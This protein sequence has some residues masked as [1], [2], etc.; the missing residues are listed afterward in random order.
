[1]GSV[2]SCV[3]GRRVPPD[4]TRDTTGHHAPTAATR[5]HV[6]WQQRLSQVSTIFPRVACT[7]Q[8]DT[9]DCSCPALAMR[10]P[11]DCRA[12][13]RQS[14]LTTAWHGARAPDA[15]DVLGVWQCRL[16]LEGPPDSSSASLIHS[17]LP[18]SCCSQVPLECA[19][20]AQGPH[21]GV[22]SNTD[23]ACSALH[24]LHGA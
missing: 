12:S 9:L 17:R 22:G 20:H 2:G 13:R 15:N 24:P 3:G 5:H 8:L 1:M 18:L 21:L 10:A 16:P 14:M 7:P 6:V 19:Q 4:T 11:N 23:G